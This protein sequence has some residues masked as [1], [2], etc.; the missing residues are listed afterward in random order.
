MSL[1]P[2]IPD[3]APFDEAQRAWLNGFLAGLSSEASAGAAAAPASPAIPVTIAYGSQ[4]GTAE[5]LSKKAAKQLKAANCDPKVL[6]LDACSLEDLAA[7]ERLLLITS[8][9]G[10]GEPPDNAQAF[11]TA[12]HADSAPRLEHLQFSVLGLGDSSYPDFCQCSKEF[13][14]RLE[15]LGAQRSA[16]MVECDGDPDEGFAAWMQAVTESLTGA[17]APMASDSEDSEEAEAS[18]YSKKNPFPAKCLRS[19]NLNAAGSAKATHH[20]EISLEGSGLE[21]E[22][23]DALGVFPENSAP[24]VSEFLLACGLSPDESVRLPDGSQQPI[25]RVLIEQFDLMQLTEDF[26]RACGRIAVH[27][28][29]QSLLQDTDAAKAY[30]QGRNLID[31][32]LDFAVKFPT[33][34]Y[35][36]A[37]LKPLKPRLYSIS[38]SPKAHPGEVHLT[39]GKVVYESHGRQR[40]GICSN[41]LAQ[42]DAERPVKVYLHSNSAFRLPENTE[43]PVIMIGPGTGIAPFRAFLEERAAQAATGRNWLFFGD[44]HSQTDF[45]YQ[46]QLAD[47]QK[48]GL[49]TQLDTAFSRDQAEKVYVQNR[50]LEQADRFYEWLEAGAYIY[51]CGDA[52]RMAKDVDAAIHQVVEKA[53]G[54]SAEQ[55]AAYV[56]EL[57]KAKR[58]LRDV[59]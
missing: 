20:V 37:L 39:V 14:A 59:Y 44:Q 4:T 31:P 2:F 16:A 8:T 43:A 46:E 41:Y 11:H 27:P 42:P 26:L 55:A 48:S 50:I 5:T 34:E 23:G 6:D 56:A 1:V 22:V 21:Y 54:H 57:K 17:E 24:A 49:L 36:L 40:Q 51:V 9:Y 53:A 52:S 12:L 10:E 47:W 38:S 15:A 7:V 45:L 30:C 13:D 25:E 33:A 32:V 58:Y 29:L 35:L 3:S 28:D 18:A 19:E